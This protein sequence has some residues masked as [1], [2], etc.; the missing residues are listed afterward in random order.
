MRSISLFSATG[1]VLGV[2]PPSRADA[3][4]AVGELGADGATTTPVIA[5]R[6]TI[7]DATEMNAMRTAATDCGFGPRLDARSVGCKRPF[8]RV[9][10]PHG[11]H[12][13]AR[14]KVIGGGGTPPPSPRLLRWTTV[15]KPAREALFAPWRGLSGPA[16]RSR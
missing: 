16:V 14:R 4:T 13:F 8:L 10:A 2:I 12:R 9:L 7:C 11:K 1:A 15:Q 3:I 6:A 5:A